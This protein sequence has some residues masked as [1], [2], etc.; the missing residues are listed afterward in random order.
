MAAPWW[1]AAVYGGRRWRCFSTSGTLSRRTAPLGPMPN[2]DIDVSNLERLEKYRSFDRYRRRAEQ[3]ARAPHWW[4][5]YR[6]HFGEESDPKDKID[7]GLP[8]PKV[9]RTQQLLERKR[10]L[11]ELRASVEEERAARLRTASI[12][13]EAVRAEWERTSGPY[14]KQRLAEYYGLYRDLFHGAT[15]V[16]R[17]P[18]HVAYAVGEDDLMPVYHGNEVTP[19]EAA[20]APEV[21][22][23]ADEGSMWTL[24]LTNLEPTSRATGWLKDRRH[25]PTCP[26]SL[27][28]APASTAL[29]SYSS[30]R[31]SRLTSPGTPGPHPGNLIYTPHT[32]PPQGLRPASQ[33]HYQLAQRT[34]HTFDFYK[35]H[36][37]AMTPA[38]LAFF[39]CHWDDSV[40]QVF[41]QLLDMREP[42]FEF[43][44]PPPYH[45]EQKRFPHRQP[46]RYLDRYRD[47]HEPTYGIY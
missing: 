33:K 16:P 3:E 10:V 31:T 23:E 8:P 42:V 15:F 36:Q 38:G 14:H 46:L 35:K 34:F 30:S 5:T 4:R 27:L 18:L 40:T 19:T 12:P 43:V 21:T 24:L 2:E 11:R 13:L 9:C 20:Q 6:E 7:I 28:E 47:S 45:P 32:H 22:Y 44:W 17:V 29:P 37:E 25:V 41:H 39:Q 1:R 26:P